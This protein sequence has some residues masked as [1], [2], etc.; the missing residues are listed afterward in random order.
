[1]NHPAKQRAVQQTLLH[2]STLKAWKITFNTAGRVLTVPQLAGCTVHSAAAHYVSNHTAASALR[3][4]GSLIRKVMSTDPPSWCAAEEYGVGSGA[5]KLCNVSL[6]IGESACI[7]W[8]FGIATD[9]TFDASLVRH[10]HCYGTA[11]DPSVSYM[12]NFLG[13]HV[14]FLGVGAR[15]LDSDWFQAG[16]WFLADVPLLAKALSVRKLHVLKM[17]C[18]GCEYGLAQSVLEHNPCFFHAVDQFAVEI[19]ITKLIAKTHAHLLGLGRLYLILE[20]A[21]LN[22]VSAVLGPCN[23]QHAA[24]GSLDDF[25]KYNYPSGNAEFCQNLLFAKG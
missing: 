12:S 22:L 5:H 20:N 1:M 7:F 4:L 3:R 15:L 17:D 10:H 23:D 8:S 21:G 18:E 25:R 6:Y 11:F 14:E 2:A 9:S 16:E 24:A 13:E 19:H